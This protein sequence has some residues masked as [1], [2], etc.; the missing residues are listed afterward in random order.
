MRLSAKG[1]TQGLLNA[2]QELHLWL[3][4][5]SHKR[6]LR[7]LAWLTLRKSGLEVT[8]EDTQTSPVLA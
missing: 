6:L 4:T 8:Q 2:R 7:L 3:R 1:R 5:P